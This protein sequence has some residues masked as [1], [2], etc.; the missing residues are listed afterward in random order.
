MFRGLRVALLGML[1]G[2]GLQ[3]CHAE[4]EWA[5]PF[6]PGSAIGPSLAVS[7]AP[8][9]LR[10]TS[11]APTPGRVS[12]VLLR[13]RINGGPALRLLLDSGAEHLVIDQ[14]SATA[15]GV[16]ARS[17]SLLVGAGASPARP[18]STGIV[19]AIDI[20]PLS[21]HDFPVDVVRGKVAEG[22]DGV[23]PLSLFRAFLIR[24]DLPG[25]ILQLTPYSAA[26]SLAAG[27]P[28]VPGQSLLLVK[29]VL[30]RARDGYVL[31]DTG[32]SF[33]AIS[34]PVARDLKQSR[35]SDASPSIAR[36]GQGVRIQIG[37][38]ELTPD[39]VV[40]IDLNTASRYNGFEIAGL[41]GFPELRLS[42]L[43]VNYRDS[44]LTIGP[45]R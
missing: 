16:L 36:A 9:T 13:A 25:K 12:G 43:T 27:V 45:A 35:I 15:S 40:A 39:R 23:V 10:L 11:F 31:L 34:H 3:P 42:V 33:T 1:L 22:I 29:A 6:L 44:Q 32:S 24:L 14:R 5:Y 38:W 37:D 18:A 41:V 26:N 28:T 17:E 19:Q 8:Y 20:G 2:T 4:S 7:N 21:F 30:D